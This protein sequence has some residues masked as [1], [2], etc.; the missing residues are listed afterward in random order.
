MTTEIRDLL[1]CSKNNTSDAFRIA[2][3]LWRITK[4]KYFSGKYL[5]I[6]FQIIS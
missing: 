4:Y 2:V 1:I 3:N 5:R 6:S